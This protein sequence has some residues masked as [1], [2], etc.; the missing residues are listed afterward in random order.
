MGIAYSL[1][2]EEIKIWFP[3]HR[4]CWLHLLIHNIWHSSELSMT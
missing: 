1:R 4:N 2:K 3:N